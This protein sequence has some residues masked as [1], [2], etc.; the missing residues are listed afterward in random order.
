[1]VFTTAVW[2]RRRYTVAPEKLWAKKINHFKDAPE[3]EE[4][5][6]SGGE[7]ELV[8]F[9]RESANFLKFIGN[10]EAPESM[11]PLRFFYERRRE[12]PLLKV[13]ADPLLA[14]PATSAASEGFFS[15]GRRTITDDRGR[16]QPRRAG[17]LIVSGIRHNIRLVGYFYFCIFVRHI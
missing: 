11:D 5:A 17:R 14:M 6:E 1:M 8:M 4:E 2:N 10:L 13:I 12:F 7:G 16:L 3:D 9:A 15:Q